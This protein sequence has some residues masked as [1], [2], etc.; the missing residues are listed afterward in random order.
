MKYA[1]YMMDMGALRLMSLSYEVFASEGYT[2]NPVVRSCIDRITSCITSVDLQVYP[3]DSKSKLE[4]KENH[5][6]LTLLNKPNPTMSGDDFLTAFVSSYLID[7]NA[8]VFGTN[9]DEKA[10]KKPPKELYVYK[11]S[12]VKVI[13][14]D[15]LG[16]P[17]GY[18]YNTNNTKTIYPVD[19]ITGRSAILHKKTY[20]PL[21]EW[22]GL[23]PMTAAALSIDTMNDGDKWNLRLLQNG[24]RPSGALM[25][26]ADANT[27]ANLTDEQFRRL[28]EQVES[29]YSGAN[30][31]GRPILLE[32][33]L[34]WK[35]MSINAKDMDFEKNM[36]KAA[37]S[38]AL[39]YGVPPML[40]GI[41]GDNT[42]SNMAEAKL[43]L[44]TDT[45][46]PLLDSILLSLTNW[47]A[48]MYGD[49]IVLWY[50]E[51]MIPALEPLRKQ[52]ADRIEA[53][54]TLTIN[55][56]RYA[57]GHEKVDG[58]DVL[59]VDSGKIPLELVGD[60]G[61]SEPD[62]EVNAGVE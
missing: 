23:S 48:P 8:F 6:I 51:D 46:L 1:S 62:S 4:K 55:E 22:R 34:E 53:S 43:A 14:G 24:A 32:G 49:N 37:R 59:L 20:N 36:N 3:K 41:P 29:N 16:I 45:V 47:L 57:M 19:Q 26:K 56:K 35:E 33:G 9:M 54:T 38:I 7:G 61:L 52:K 42:F 31:A 5:P 25:V 40:L 60:M 15:K 18:E 10:S 21:D 13:A 2:M 30:N 27:P 12:C 50:D 11:P 17:K 28:R 39:A 44:W 58:G